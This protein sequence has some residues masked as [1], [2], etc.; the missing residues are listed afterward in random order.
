MGGAYVIIG[1]VLNG[2]L[3]KH[4]DDLSCT[5][6]WDYCCIQNALRCTEFPCNPDC[7]VLIDEVPCASIF[8]ANT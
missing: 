2:K 5:S 6:T 4:M 1:P 3:W 8:Y 7:L